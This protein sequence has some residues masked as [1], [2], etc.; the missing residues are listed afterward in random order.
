MCATKRAAVWASWQTLNNSPDI[1]IPVMFQGHCQA[2]GSLNDSGSPS[3]QQ[4]TWLRL[5]HGN[6][7][8]LC[9]PLKHNF[10][11]EYQNCTALHFICINT[12]S[13]IRIHSLFTRCQFRD[14]KLPK[15]QN[16]QIGRCIWHKWHCT[17]DCSASAIIRIGAFS[18][19]C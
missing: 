16:G 13:A 10:I 17:C 15:S 2:L 6:L 11:P 1:T 14:M 19:C 7:C 18:L 9:I 3:L 4:H 12:T 8:E 5:N